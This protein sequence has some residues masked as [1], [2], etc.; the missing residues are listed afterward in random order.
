[1][2]RNPLLSLELPPEECLIEASISESDDGS[3]W[4]EFTF[5][6]DS[7]TEEN[8]GIFANAPAGVFSIYWDPNYPHEAGIQPVSYTH[9]D[10]YKRQHLYNKIFRLNNTLFGGYLII[11][12][13]AVCILL[14]G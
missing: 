11:T 3:I 7:L 6:G 2:S 4:C 1:M 13:N 9:L 12:F 8:C 14:L 10:V 5:N